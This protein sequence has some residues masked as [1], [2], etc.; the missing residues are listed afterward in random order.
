M[1]MATTLEQ[2]F[3]EA[4]ELTPAQRAELADFLVES[5][6]STPPDEV[7]R[8]WIR[9]ANERL[10]EIRAGAVQTIPGEEVLA[11]ARR[12]IKR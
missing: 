11:E 8:L 9:E 4:L 10:A 12:L 7:Q 3:R 2:L 5:L 6:E 1:Y